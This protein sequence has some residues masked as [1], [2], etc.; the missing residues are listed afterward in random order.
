MKKIILLIFVFIS[1][2]VNVFAQYKPFQFGLKAAPG[3][4]RIKLNSDN[5]DNAQNEISFNWGF[6]G[7]FYFV[8]NYG[9]STGFNI[10]NVKN[11]YDYVADDK[12]IVNRKIDNQYLEIPFALMMRTEKIDKIRI[13][14]NVG[15][16]LGICLKSK[17]EDFVGEAEIESENEFDPI[18]HGLIIKAGVEF[19]VYKS[20]CLT[21][22]FVYN[23]NFA[24]I[25]KKDN[26]LGHNVFL[27]NLCLE[28]GFMF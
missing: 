6:K 16:G 25:Y 10:L 27:N 22:A 13:F 11:S 2:C 21:A 18:R 5:I 26:V 15:Y 3:I 19:N 24:N 4:N 8:E 9:I 17:Q 1:L 23:G 14:G 20:S 7:N 12:K 28:I